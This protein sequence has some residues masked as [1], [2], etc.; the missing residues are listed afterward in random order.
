ML[1]SALTHFF[2]NF[3]YFRDSSLSR[4]LKVPRGLL[5][6]IAGPGNYFCRRETWRSHYF[7]KGVVFPAAQC[8]L[9][10]L[11][12][13]AAHSNRQMCRHCW[14]STYFSWWRRLGQ[15][16]SALVP[17]SSACTDTQGCSFY[18]LSPGWGQEE[19][20]SQPAL[21]L[22]IPVVKIQHLDPWGERNLFG[23]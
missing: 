15:S 7:T 22:K 3:F 9:C 18:L 11:L 23:P 16:S 1:P 10:P 6:P 8:N 12:L 2:E 19:L 4:C 14:S 20:Q 17:A 13:P 21:C 5:I